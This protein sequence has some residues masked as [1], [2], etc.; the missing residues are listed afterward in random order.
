[1]IIMTDKKRLYVDVNIALYEEYKRCLFDD[2][3]VIRK[4]TKLYKYISHDVSTLINILC[5][6][7]HAL[8]YNNLRRINKKIINAYG[9]AYKR[10]VITLE[11][12]VFD[13]LMSMRHQR[14]DV[15]SLVNYA[16][17]CR[18]YTYNNKR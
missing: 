10:K 9:N 4:K 15:D 11:D 13:M 7:P 17:M 3:K 6:K 2:D 12:D 5:D 16:F 14:F 1:M 8:S 18:V